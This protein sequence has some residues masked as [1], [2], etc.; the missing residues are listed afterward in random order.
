MEKICRESE[1]QYEQNLKAFCK[2]SK[3]A[4]GKELEKCKSV[5]L[6]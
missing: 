4:T 3:F 5:G 2:E 6:R 1:V